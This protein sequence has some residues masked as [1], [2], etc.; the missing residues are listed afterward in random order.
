VEI[1]ILT[2]DT[3]G[4]TQKENHIHLS[5]LACPF[6]QRLLLFHKTFLRVCLRSQTKNV[7]QLL[8]KEW[9]HRLDPQT[10]ER[11]NFSMVDCDV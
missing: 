5:F 9:N 3:F 2:R 7:L 1:L 10:A 8:F 4:F 11:N 6:N